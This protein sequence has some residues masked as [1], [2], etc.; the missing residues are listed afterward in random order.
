MHRG[1]DVTKLL[2]GLWLMV[3]DWSVQKFIMLDVLLHFENNTHQAMLETESSYNSLFYAQILTFLMESVIHSQRTQGTPR[4]NPIKYLCVLQQVSESTK[5][6]LRN[7]CVES[8]SEQHNIQ[9]SKRQ[10]LQ[11]QLKIRRLIPRPLPVFFSMFTRKAGG[12]GLQWHVTTPITRSSVF[13]IIVGG[14]LTYLYI[15][16]DSQILLPAIEGHR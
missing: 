14:F 12:S 2:S 1:H 16:L 9:L 4:A 8:K 13:E 6:R 11:F 3:P 10:T 7:I 15:S 5:N